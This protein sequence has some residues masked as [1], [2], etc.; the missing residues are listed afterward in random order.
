MKQ[1]ITYTKNGVTKTST[2]NKITEKR[3]FSKCYHNDNYKIYEISDD[4]RSIR[5]V[6]MDF[7]AKM[8]S[9]RCQCHQ[10]HVVFENCTFEGNCQILKLGDGYATVF[11]NCH[12]GDD[13]TL[14]ADDP[15]LD[16]TVINENA[17]DK[18]NYHVF[19]KKMYLQS[20]KNKGNIKIRAKEV[21]VVGVDNDNEI[22]LI[23]D[24]AQIL[25]SSL[26]ATE[27]I[28]KKIELIESQI[29]S[30]QMN[31]LKL[32]TE[33]LQGS[34][35]SLLSMSDIQIGPD[36]YEKG[37]LPFLLLTDEEIKAKK[38]TKVKQ[39]TPVRQKMTSYKF[40]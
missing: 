37:T 38:K 3:I 34:E 11:Y 31:T 13:L 1:E 39:P 9:F 33:E 40:N 24:K 5:F 10:T 20:N 32:N 21:T 25:Y 18:I 29:I 30:S 22:S 12:F 15:K 19:C 17:E 16:I 36:T 35:Y 7:S 2:L 27:I 26:M 23:A 14:F 8:V 6:N 4:I 28:C